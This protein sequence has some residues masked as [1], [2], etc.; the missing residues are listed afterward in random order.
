MMRRSLIPI[1][2][3]VGFLL[4]QALTARVHAEPD[5]ALDR[6][7]VE[8]MVRAMESQAHATEDLVRATERCK[9]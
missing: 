6:Q 2:L 5:P 3:L 8:R 7:L 4:G 9:H 1:A